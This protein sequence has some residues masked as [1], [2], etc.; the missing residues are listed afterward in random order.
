M[1]QHQR[2]EEATS[3][4]RRV[5]GSTRT[6]TVPQARSGPQAGART[7][8]SVLALQRAA[9]NAAVA[10]ALSS[11]EAV[12]VQRMLPTPTQGGQNLRDG[13]REVLSMIPAF[14]VPEEVFGAD[15]SLP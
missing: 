7:P 15:G 11:G 1:R 13:Q 10:R 4:A 8:A 12:Q 9:G 6:R 3:H 14:Y 2:M 5:P